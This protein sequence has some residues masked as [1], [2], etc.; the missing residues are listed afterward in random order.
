MC[1]SSSPR[2]SLLGL[3]R[4]VLLAEV[5]GQCDPGGAVVGA[6]HPC[7]QGVVGAPW[8]QKIRK[9]RHAAKFTRHP[10]VA[11]R[12]DL[13]FGHRKVDSFGPWVFVRDIAHV[14]G[15][16]PQHERVS[17]CGMECA[18]FQRSGIEHVEVGCP[19]TDKI[20]HTLQRRTPGRITDR[21]CM[22]A[23]DRCQ[24][25]LFEILPIR[26]DHRSSDPWDFRRI[27]TGVAPR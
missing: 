2:P 24:Q 21:R 3:W 18:V 16:V 10:D 13:P 11:V 5:Q 12:N 14:V 9:E 17:P 8:L 7:V 27:A 19:R 25:R 26:P 15:D 4:T 1:G 23:I 20:A 22:N 6:A